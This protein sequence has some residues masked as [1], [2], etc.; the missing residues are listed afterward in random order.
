[1]SELDEESPAQAPAGRTDDVVLAEK[2][3][4]ASMIA[5]RHAAEEA[6]D[7]LGGEHPTNH[8]ELVLDARDEANRNAG[9]RRQCRRRCGGSSSYHG[10]GSYGPGCGCGICLLGGQWWWRCRSEGRRHPHGGDV[11]LCGGN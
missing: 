1:M 7:L 6:L 10:R 3:V 11:R 5:Y 2:A 8:R 4:V 9:V